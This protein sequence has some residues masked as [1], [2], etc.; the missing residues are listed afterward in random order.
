[1]NCPPSSDGRRIL[2]CPTV[3][4][5]DLTPH[6]YGWHE[7]KNWIVL[8]FSRNLEKI[9]DTILYYLEKIFPSSSHRNLNGIALTGRKIIIAEAYFTLLC[10]F[11]CQ[12]VSACHILTQLILRIV[13]Y[14]LTLDYFS[15]QILIPFNYMNCFPTVLIERNLVFGSLS[16]RFK[17]WFH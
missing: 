11:W 12:N 4:V 17:N 13:T 1:M 10:L 6:L 5:A 14:K 7:S 16:D 2:V 15:N 3:W 8:Y 9:L